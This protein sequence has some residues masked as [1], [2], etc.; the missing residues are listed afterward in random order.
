MYVVLSPT[1]PAE[2]NKRPEQAR[3]TKNQVKN[4]RR[5][6][7]K[8]EKQKQA[9]DDG[10]DNS[11]SGTPNKRVI[12]KQ[13]PITMDKPANASDKGGGIGWSSASERRPKG[14]ATRSSDVPTDDDVML[15]TED[16]TITK[17]KPVI[18]DE[19]DVKND[20]NATESVSVTENVPS[21]K[22]KSAAEN[23]LLISKDD[24][25]SEDNESTAK[26]DIALESYTFASKAESDTYSNASGETSDTPGI[27]SGHPTIGALMTKS[28]TFSSPSG[29]DLRTFKKDVWAALAQTTCAVV[30]LC[31]TQEHVAGA[32]EELARTLKDLERVRN[33]LEG[34]QGQVERAQCKLACSVEAMQETEKAL[35]ELCERLV[36]V[37]RV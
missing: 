3:K 32:Q 8:K 21:T 24:P 27:T 28:C 37:L 14:N 13:A 35:R 26:K 34:T 16:H 18:S 30:S 25:D 11:V 12:L 29:E 23:E 19:S 9:G 10:H 22:D 31:E 7:K 33:K 20:P 15:K 5:R 2:R 17:S 4:A 1:N 6:Q 36:H